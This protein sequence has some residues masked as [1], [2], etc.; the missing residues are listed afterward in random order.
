MGKHRGDMSALGHHGEGGDK[1]DNDADT[2]TESG[3]FSHMEELRKRLIIAMIACVIGFAAC[4]N[5]SQEL[6][7][8]IAEPVKQVLPEGRSLVFIHAT[9]PFFTYLKV[10]A[11]AGVILALPVILWQVW[12][13]VAPALYAGEKRLAVPFVLC[14]C[15]CFG[16]GT[17][18]GFTFVFPVIFKFLISFGMGSGD[19]EAMLSM[20]GYLSMSIRLLLAFGLVFE[21]PIVIFFLAR[22]GIVD[23]RWLA[24]NRRYAYLLAFVIGAMLTP[25]DLFSQTS[26]AMPFIILYEVGIWVARFFG[27][28]PASD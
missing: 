4:Y 24:R 7:L 8:F 20:A 25:P 27:K 21:L 22:M 9:E 13:F 16:V 5:F 19:M 18:F 6:F 28:K 3:F 26:I 17:Y 11:V 10:S 2:P 1:T 15:L 14:S 23:Y 12:G